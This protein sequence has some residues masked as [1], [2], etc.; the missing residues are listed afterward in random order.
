MNT[1]D[2]DIDEFGLRIA[3]ESERDWL[4]RISLFV[5]SGTAAL[6]FTVFALPT[7]WFAPSVAV[8]I[9]ALF[10]FGNRIRHRKQLVLRRT[11]FF[12]HGGDVPN[13]I[14]WRAVAKVELIKNRIEFEFKNG[15]RKLLRLGFLPSYERFPVAIEFYRHW[16]MNQAAGPL[17]FPPVSEVAIRTQNLQIEPVAESDREFFLSLSAA[18][19]NSRYH[20]EPPSSPEWVEMNFEQLVCSVRTN[21][22]YWNCLIRTEDKTPIG[23]IVLSL[24]CPI[25]RQAIMGLDLLTEFQNRG[26]GTEAI[27]GI[28]NFAKQRTNLSKVTANCFSDNTACIRALEKAGMKRT[29]TFEKFW[30]KDGTWKSGHQ[31]EMVF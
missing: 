21:P 11:D 16:E 17:E 14:P 18:E 2:V 25:L 1:E 29:G 8:L 23:A 5:L 12:T 27:E 26:Y 10:W 22:I 3:A 28:L 31:Y 9:A 4:H 15:S 24:D 19:E 30:F 13:P 20:L 7:N 6:A